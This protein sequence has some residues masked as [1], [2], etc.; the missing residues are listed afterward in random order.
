MGPF[1]RTVFASARIRRT[2]RR[3]APDVEPHLPAW[4]L[5]AARSVSAPPWS[6]RA[7]RPRSGAR[8]STPRSSALALARARPRTVGSTRLSPICLPRSDEGERHRAADEQGVTRS[9]SE[10]MVASLSETFAPRARRRTGG[11]ARR[12]SFDRA[13]PRAR[14]ACR[15]AVG[16]PC[17]IMDRR[18]GRHGSVAAVHRAERVVHVHVRVRQPLGE[19]RGRW[20]PHRVEAQVLQQDDTTGLERSAWHACSTSGLRNAVRRSVLTSRPR[21]SE[22]PGGDGAHACVLLHL[23][24]R[25]RGEAT[26]S[27]APPSSSSSASQRRRIRVSS[28]RVPSFSGT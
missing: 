4:D 17:S 16:R 18:Q 13:P 3:S 8:G 2:P 24:F 22:S 12:G 26:T 23:P 11:R 21:S 19:T 25:R 27:D 10:P 1:H 7:P 15:A 14:A 20:P 9:T 28:V 6:S 5:V